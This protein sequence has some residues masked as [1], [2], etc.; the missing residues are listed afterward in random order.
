MLREKTQHA[1][2]MWFPLEEQAEWITVVLVTEPSV[3][4]TEAQINK[5]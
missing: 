2:T 3:Q 5:K 4:I 1:Q